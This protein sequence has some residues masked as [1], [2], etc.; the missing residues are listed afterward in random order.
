M[1]DTGRTLQMRRKFPFFCDHD[2]LFKED[3]KLMVY[4][5]MYYGVCKRCG[6]QITV[7]K[8][9]YEKYYKKPEK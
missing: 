8:E 7:D 5:P 4:P 2:Y 3:T 1:P 6:A 9:T